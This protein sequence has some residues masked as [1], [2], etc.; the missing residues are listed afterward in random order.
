MDFAQDFAKEYLTYK[1]SGEEEFKSRIKPYVSRRIYNLSGIYSFRHSA[2]AT[3]VHAYRRVENEGVYDVYVRAEVRYD[4][5]EESI[6]DTC[7]LKIPVSA[8]QA[9]YC[10]TSLPLYVQDSQLDTTY[11]AAELTWGVEIDSTPLEGSVR[12]FFETYYTQ[13][14]SMINYLLTP[15]ADKSKFLGMDHRYAFLQ[16]ESLKAYQN[17]GET[18]IHCIVKTRIQDTVNEEEIYQ[19]CNLVLVE[20]NEKYYVKDME[21]KITGG[22]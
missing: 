15:D 17:E 9:G 3:Y 22:Y 4:Q 5:E 16:I 14:Q 20:S 10:V 21:T 12:N 7:T 18:D 11:N 6:Y 2:K 8:T 13:E 19:E 1:Q